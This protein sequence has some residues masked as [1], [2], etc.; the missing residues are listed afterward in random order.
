MRDMLLE[1]IQLHSAT[2]FNFFMYRASIYIIHLWQSW[3]FSVPL[4]R[5]TILAVLII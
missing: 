5:Q 1:I 3:F 2:V 4:F